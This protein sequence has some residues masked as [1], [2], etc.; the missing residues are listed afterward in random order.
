LQ[1]YKRAAKQDP[2]FHQQVSARLAALETKPQSWAQLLPNI[3]LRSKYSRNMQ[4][5]SGD[6]L[7]SFG[8][9]SFEYNSYDYALSLSQP[10]FHFDRLIQLDQADSRVKQAEMEF[11]AAVQD[12]MVRVAERYFEVLAAQ[13]NF[14][15][16]TAER[17]ALEQQFLEAKQRTELGLIA[18]TDL[19]EA[20]AGYDLAATRE[21]QAKGQLDMAREA[22]RETAGRYYEDLAPLSVELP[23]APPEPMDIE[24]WTAKALEQNLAILAARQ[25]LET[26][27][28]EIQRQRAGHLP[29]L[30]L[31]GSHGLDVTGG[32]FGATETEF[33]AVGLTLNVPLYQGGA[34]NSKTREARYRHNEA[35]DRLEQQRRAAQRQAREAFLN[36]LVNINQVN[37]FK[38]A[39]TSARASVEATQ[40]GIEFGTRVGVDLV[41]A[42]RNLFQAKRDYARARYDYALNLLRLK[43]ATGVL[44]PEDIAL[45]NDW[46]IH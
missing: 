21:V 35:L 1:I 17:H 6:G 16:A 36:V 29:T 38:Q 40:A 20:Q 5:V 23:L 25:A 19:Y 7:G 4:D 10:I 26:A 30:D 28:A 33:S 44:K 46:L 22:L 24:R 45:V 14:D 39:V 31:T 43:R 42:E 27:R 9:G 41:L 18:I 37:A 15:F 13:D 32:R 11:A 12:L 3:G 34:V 2:F 8:G